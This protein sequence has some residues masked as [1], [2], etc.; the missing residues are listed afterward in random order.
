MTASTDEASTQSGAKGSLV[1]AIGSLGIAVLALNSVIGGGIFGL[2]PRVAEQMGMASPWLFLLVGVLVITIVLTFAELASYFRDSGGPVLFTTKAFGPVVGFGTG[3][4][5]YISRISAFAANAS[6]LAAYIGSLWAPAASGVGRV[7]V[8]VAACVGL[9][10]ANYVGVKDGVRTL[11]VLTVLKL[12]PILLLILV[13]LPYVS[14]ETVIPAELPPMDGI[15]STILLMMFAFVGFEATT[16][17]SGESKDPRRSLP[18]AL[19][20]TTLF[21][22]AF[23]FLIVLVYVAALPNIDDSQGTLVALGEHLL[24]PVGAIAITLAAVFSIG[25]NLGAILLAVPRL[26]FALA[27]QRLLP[28]WFGRVHERY[29][30]PGNS[31]LFLGGAGLLLAL[32]GSFAFLAVASA[33]T[34]LIT[35]IL[36]IAALPIIRRQATEEDRER[37]Y[38]LKG[39]YTIPI[40]A[41]AISVWVAAQSALESWLLTGGLFAIGVALFAVARLSQRRADGGG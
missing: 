10:W 21:I 32:S 6:L 11:S 8:I 12:T 39:G 15:G 19:V 28:A 20:K 41:L 17:V 24:G 31:I 25:G 9:T 33:L 14:A 29:A 22:A 30:T 35:Y 5:Y 37:V 36:S 1:R 26:T 2:P 16:I 40:L 23:Y 38:R 3:W 18:S 34:R 4:I 7:A 27:E 13:G